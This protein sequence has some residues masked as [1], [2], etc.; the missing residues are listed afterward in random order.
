MI[1]WR[2]WLS[3]RLVEFL[4]Y[5]CIHIS[6]LILVTHLSSNYLFLK[7]ALIKA[8]A[9]THTLLSLLSITLSIWWGTKRVL[10]RAIFF[11][12]LFF[13]RKCNYSCVLFLKSILRGEYCCY[14]IQYK[15]EPDTDTQLYNL[16]T[17]HHKN[18]CLKQM[19]ACSRDHHNSCGVVLMQELM[20]LRERALEIKI[21]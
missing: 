3:V 8:L 13:Y 10:I 9:S 2:G 20:L 6:L 7:P 5:P 19:C 1:G 4:K 16:A 15:W 17:L 21:L 14:T 18:H 12:F 11:S